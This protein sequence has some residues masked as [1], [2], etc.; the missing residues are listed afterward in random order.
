M[1]S[2][3]ILEKHLS[4]YLKKN[5]TIINY[6]KSRASAVTNHKLKFVSSAEPIV[7]IGINLARMTASVT[8]RET[9]TK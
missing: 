4:L 9:L 6:G 5:F 3:W 1:T 7:K 2:R 8:S